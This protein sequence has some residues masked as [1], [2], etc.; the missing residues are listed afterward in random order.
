M[1]VIKAPMYF[2]ETKEI[3]NGHVVKYRMVNTTY[4]GKNIH[5]DNQFKRLLLGQTSKIN[6]LERLKRDYNMTHKKKTHKNKTHK[7]KRHL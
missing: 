6:L 4:D 2:G 5:V 7:N 3:V 1:P